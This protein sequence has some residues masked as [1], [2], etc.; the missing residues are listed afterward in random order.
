MHFGMWPTGALVP[1]LTQHFVAARDDA[2]HP[3]IGLGGEQT[4]LGQTQ[5]ARHV[6]VVGD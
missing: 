2:A 4:A 1:A 3:R 6:G 5:R